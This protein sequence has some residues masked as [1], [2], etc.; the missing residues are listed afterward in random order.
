[1]PRLFRSLTRLILTL[2]LLAGGAFAQQTRVL[3]WNGMQTHGGEVPSSLRKK[4]AD[5]I[6]AYGGG[7]VYDVEYEASINPGALAKRLNAGKYDVLVL[8]VT[9]NYIRVNA[10][11]LSAVQNFY[12]SGNQALMLD[13][14]F[15]IRSM[16]NNPL[17]KFPGRNDDLAKLTVNQIE[18]LATRGG[19]I[20]IGADHDRF[21]ANSNKILTAL[22][23][24]AKFTGLT[25]P[26]TDGD[27]FG[28][29]LLNQRESA[30]PK[31]IF[32]H[33]VSVPSQGEAPVGPFVDFMGQPLTLFS[34]A[35]ASDLPGG[36][37]RRPYISANFDPGDKRTA[38]DS[39]TE[40][41]DN[42]PTHKSPQ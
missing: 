27:F 22:V 12:S 30:I 7:A 2:S 13:G 37:V 18:A 5:Y 40:A 35:E 20:L 28:D 16:N 23:P 6:N 4:M 8:D 21:Q 15:A 1:M 10:A 38:I 33:W 42:I 39:E 9:D 32:D 41:F 26:S 29:A 24:D 25:K 19:G 17:T 11:D 36:G 14:S 34:L 3:F 31:N